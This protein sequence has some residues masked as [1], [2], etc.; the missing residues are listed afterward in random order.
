MFSSVL[1]AA[2]LGLEVCPVQVE[3]DV[4]NGLPSFTIV[5][6]ASSQVKEAQDRVRTALRNVEI[7]LPPKRITINLSPAHIRKEGA[8]FDLPVAASILCAMGVLPAHVLDQVMMAGEVSLSG[9]I[10]RISGILPIAIRARELGCKAC[11][12]PWENLRE[13]SLVEDLPVIG[14]RSLRDLL[15]YCQNPEAY[16]RQR[17]P[18]SPIS[19]KP[20]SKEVDFADIQGQEPLKRAAEI[21]AGGFHN[22]L[23]IGPPGSGK[24]M[25]ARRLPTIL[26]ALTFEESL[27]LTKI[28]SIAGLL[29]PEQPILTA[30]PFRAPHHTASPQALAGGGRNPRPGEV[31]LAHR[32]VLFLDEIPEFSKR[33]LEILRQ[34]LE[35]RMIQLSRVHGTYVFP[36]NFLLVA[37]M[38]P[39]PCGYYPDMNRCT[40]SPGSVA[41]YLG[42]LSQPLLDRIDLCVEAPEVTYQQL[43]SR[44]TEES[45]AR[46]RERVEKVHRIQK[47]R[48]EGME[49]HYNSELQAS[50]MEKFCPV[51][52][53]GQQI[54]EKAYERLHLS[55]RGY[56]RILK[57]A[58][59]IADMEESPIIRGDH[60]R[61]ALTYRTPDKKYW[62]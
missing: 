30:R 28:Y 38:N 18:L 17:P 40:C 11:I 4:S 14:L 36:A 35:D 22:L 27:E 60:I 24:T 48:Y 20:V 6:F 41:H 23:F 21:A 7:S 43:R 42:K 3:A 37:A 9:K 32:S 13:A 55:A 10:S 53:E 5:G 46:I 58:R 62:K 2:I 12:V 49:V 52:T 31:T 29:T 45:S 26:P 61:E 16:W 59:T 25:I 50:M 33:S 47:Q 54:L 44:K 39:C 8:G 15:T 51:E 1:S 56:H 34:P 19:E 57:V